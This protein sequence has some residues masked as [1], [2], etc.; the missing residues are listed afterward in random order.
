MMMVRVYVLLLEGEDLRGP[1][2]AV[3]FV[4][5]PRARMMTKDVH[6]PNC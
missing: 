5:A 1:L 4:D 6:V 3:E 2:E